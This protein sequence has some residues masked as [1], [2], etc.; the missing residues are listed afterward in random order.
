MHSSLDAH[1]TSSSSPIST[2]NG[3]RTSAC[4]VRTKRHWDWNCHGDRQARL[5]RAHKH[6]SRRRR[7]GGAGGDGAACHHRNRSRH[8]RA[9]SNH[10]R[11][12]VPGAAAVPSREVE[13][14]AAERVEAAR[15][16]AKGFGVDLQRR[17]I[18]ERRS[19]CRR[20]T[21]L[22]RRGSEAV[23]ER[24]GVG[25]DA[26]EHELEL[27]QAGR[28]AASVLREPPRRRLGGGAARLEGS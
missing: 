14:A 2:H 17:S 3:Q 18:G 7:L 27:P 26:V 20:V 13:R 8:W 9:W 11:T 5:H 22:L 6:N 15:P 24:G 25:A 23:R 16:V 19:D 12:A 28:A 1:G 4:L 10:S 21:Q